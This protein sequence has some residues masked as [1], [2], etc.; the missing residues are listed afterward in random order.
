MC[1][2]KSDSACLKNKTKRPTIYIITEAFHSI[3]RSI[4]VHCWCVR[5]YKSYAAVY[6]VRTKCSAKLF[7]AVILYKHV[8]RH[9]HIMYVQ[10]SVYKTMFLKLTIYIFTRT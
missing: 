10:C 7:L 9:S 3:Y 1:Q 5:F 4:H 6:Q 8:F 2:R